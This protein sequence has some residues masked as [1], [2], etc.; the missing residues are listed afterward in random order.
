VGGATDDGVTD[1]GVTD[2]GARPARFRAV[3]VLEERLGVPVPLPTP[4]ML[5]SLTTAARRADVVIAHG[6]V[7]PTSVYASWAAR[8]ARTP[9]VVVQHNPF[10][11]YGAVLDRVERA[12]DATLG[13]HV[14]AGADVVVCVSEHTRAYVRRLVPA[15]P[16][17]VVH[18]GVDPARHHRVQP[19]LD[20][21]VATRRVVVLRRLVARNGV[22]VL[23]DA[24]SR[25]DVPAS[26]ELVIGGSG[27]DEAA[28]RHRAASLA[29]VRFLGRVSPDEQPALLRDA[30]VVV[31][32]S[33]TGEGWGLVAAEALACGVPVIASAQG[34]LAEVVRDGENGL[35]V[36]PGDAQALA[37]SI[38]SLL[39][40]DRRRHRLAT[41]AG[42]GVTT[43]DES[44]DRLDA[45]LGGVVGG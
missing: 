19:A 20:G 10:V 6:H 5:A 31:M 42:L 30:W 1:D 45:V 34:G 14:L 23:L 9:F 28:L 37:T 3:N 40:D 33:V 13:R 43:W 38:T 41:G 8:L 11:E 7:Y 27:P 29:N 21:G 39:H 18:N 15:V 24:W 2:G 36:P 16:T 35:L 17:E 25:A 4:R 12:A 26:A 32:P 44:V 22:H